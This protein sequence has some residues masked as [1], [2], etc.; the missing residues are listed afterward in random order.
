MCLL[1]ACQPAAGPPLTT[2]SYARKLVSKTAKKAEQLQT[3]ATPAALSPLI[4][5]LSW[6]YTS[7]GTVTSSAVQNCAM[8]TLTLP[9][10]FLLLLLG[11]APRTF[12]TLKENS[13]GSMRP[14]SLYIV[15]VCRQTECRMLCRFVGCVTGASQSCTDCWQL[16]QCDSYIR[17]HTC[18]RNCCQKTARVCGLTASAVVVNSLLPRSHAKQTLSRPDGSSP[19]SSS[20]WEC[21]RSIGSISSGSGGQSGR[22][23]H[24]QHGSTHTPAAAL[25][26]WPGQATRTCKEGDD[27][28]LIL[29]RCP[30][31]C[32]LCDLNE[33]AL[34]LLLL[35]SAM[36]VAS[37]CS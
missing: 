7:C 25:L 9:I 13:L 29:E 10:V 15:H 5:H 14:P 18:L 12:C 11:S 34:G 3:K 32:H 8:S 16:S 26:C 37:C 20:A 27:L 6:R 30:A 4:A 21:N 24:Q 17:T 22:V 19:A 36:V 1:P 33:L 28:K 31:S 2:A 23:D 35:S